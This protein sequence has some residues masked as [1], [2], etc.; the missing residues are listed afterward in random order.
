[1]NNIY[2]AFEQNASWLNAAILFVLVVV[3]SAAF[4]WRK[5]KLVDGTGQPIV[6]FDGRWSYTVDDASKL[7]GDM[8]KDGRR[9]YWVT[10]V[11]LDLVFPFLYTGLIAILFFLLYSDPRYL[12][13]IPLTVLGSDLLENA[14]TVYH[15]LT[16]ESGLSAA[17]VRLGS[18][19]T[20]IKWSGAITAIVLIVGKVIY[21]I[22][23]RLFG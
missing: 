1:M 5:G 18:M 3:F 23:N 22:V 10:Q 19:F 21:N 17:M 8:G 14:T 4:E 15:V 2:Q 7:L 9:T 12:V 11:T 13:L 6:T 16:Y 20:S